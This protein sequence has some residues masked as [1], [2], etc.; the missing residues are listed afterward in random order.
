MSEFR[1]PLS[2]RVAQ[3][4][5]GGP[6]DCVVY[7]D[8]SREAVGIRDLTEGEKS[9]TLDK[10]GSVSGLIRSDQPENI[11]GCE[12]VGVVLQRVL[13]QLDLPLGEA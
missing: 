8:A 1:S 7:F 6:E 2:W 12:P 11:D 3:L 10:L 9:L 4:E 13:R 5:G